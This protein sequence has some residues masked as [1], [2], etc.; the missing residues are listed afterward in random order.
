[1]Y[2]VSWLF[3]YLNA[4]W[5]VLCTTFLELKCFLTSPHFTCKLRLLCKTDRISCAHSFVCGTTSLAVLHRSS[6]LREPSNNSST[7]SL[8]CSWALA[9]T[10]AAEAACQQNHANL[11]SHLVSGLLMVMR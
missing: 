10:K 1:M 4:S 11:E 9:G 8:C 6:S 3:K 2:F 5:V 7:H